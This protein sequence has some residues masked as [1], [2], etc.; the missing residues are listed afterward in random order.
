MRV[1]VVSRHYF[2]PGEVTGSH[3]HRQC[4]ELTRIGVDVQVICPVPR[5]NVGAARANFRKVL[6]RSSYVVLDEVPVT[7]VPYANVPHRLSVDLDTTSLRTAISRALS[8]MPDEE[9]FDLVHAHRLFPD[10]WA[11]LPVARR[12]GIPLVAT[13]H[14]SDVHTHPLRN[15]GIARCTRQLIAAS[16]RILAVS[17]ALGDQLLDVGRPLREVA[18]L[19]HGVDTDRFRPTPDK[20]SLRSR[21]GLPT[22]GVGVCCVSRLV[23]EKG[24]RELLAAFQAVASRQRDA[25][26]LLVGGG[27]ARA[28]LEAQCRAR[29]LKENVFFAGPRPNS[30]VADWL[31]ASDVF[32]LPSYKEGLPNVV[33]E[34]M[35]CGLP[36]VATDVGG[37]AE[38]VRTDC[39]LLVPSRDVVSLEQALDRLV[40][41][42]E[43]RT[44]LGGAAR[45]RIEERFTWRRS[46]VDL[47]GMYRTILADGRPRGLVDA[48]PVQEPRG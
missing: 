4:A 36:I 27:P 21:L 38:A 30:E 20:I 8:I 41:S 10:A 13:A 40:G 7:Y 14:G 37:I 18:V 31:N 43:L 24:L 6:A 2:R 44:R 23:V 29:G 16:D 1:L 5:F 25:W 33:L 46:A 45:R 15:A 34:A 47:A 42:A 17:K 3:V 12:L 26:L 48:S 35:A 22:S 19:Y 28:K 32:A 9:T 39:A 11:A